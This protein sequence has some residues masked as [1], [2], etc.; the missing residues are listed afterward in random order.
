MTFWHTHIPGDEKGAFPYLS[1]MLEPVF[2]QGKNAR[3]TGDTTNYPDGGARLR[4][5]VWQYPEP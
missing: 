2:F 3:I 1:N 4:C 5:A